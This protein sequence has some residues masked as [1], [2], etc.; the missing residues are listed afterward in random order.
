MRKR[1]FRENQAK[2]CQEIEELRSICDTETDQARQARIDELIVHATREESYDSE[3]IFDSNSGITAQSKFLVRPKN[4]YDLET[5][6][7]SG[8]TRVPVRPSAI[9]SPRTMHC[10]GSGLPHDTQIFVGTSANVLERLLA[11]KGR[12]STFFN[13]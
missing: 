9:P 1:L 5:A 6:N 8:T 2:D 11:Q 3:S 12:T 10:R 4:F 13:N 7:S